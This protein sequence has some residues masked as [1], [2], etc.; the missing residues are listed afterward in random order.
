MPFQGA[1]SEWLPSRVLIIVSIYLE[2]VRQAS[3]VAALVLM[4]AVQNRVCVPDG[5]GRL[6]VR[7]GKDHLCKTHSSGKHLLFN[8]DKFR[9]EH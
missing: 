5:S 1:I 7:R 9:G 2:P 8:L 3:K 4:E 6:P